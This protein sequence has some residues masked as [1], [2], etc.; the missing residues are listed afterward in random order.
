MSD[1]LVQYISNKQLL[2]NFV[3]G[4]QQSPLFA[5]CCTID[6]Y[7]LPY[8]THFCYSVDSQGQ[9]KAWFVAQVQFWAFLSFQLAIS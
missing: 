5:S 6:T 3:V 2:Q 9:V 7:P 1:L 8:S 4:S